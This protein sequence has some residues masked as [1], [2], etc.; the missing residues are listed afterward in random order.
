MTKK[1]KLFLEL[2]RVKRSNN[3]LTEEGIAADFEKP[4]G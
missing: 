2:L 4:E 3:L 1:Q